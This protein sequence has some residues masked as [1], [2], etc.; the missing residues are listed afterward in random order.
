M[1]GLNTLLAALDISEQIDRGLVL[2]RS[3]ANPAPRPRALPTPPRPRPRCAAAPAR[4]GA[5]R[6]GVAVLREWHS[7]FFR[8]LL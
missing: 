4:R 7:A 3:I 8:T 1:R 6:G 5:G 2:V